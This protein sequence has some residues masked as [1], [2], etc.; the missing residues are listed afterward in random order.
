M[1]S[2]KYILTAL[3][4]A[5]R[6]PANMYTR[7]EL[8]PDQ[9]PANIYSRHCGHSESGKHTHGI[10][11][12]HS[13]SGEVGIGVDPEGTRDECH[14]SDC[15]VNVIQVV[16]PRSD[17]WDV[18][19]LSVER[20]HSGNLRSILCTTTLRRTYPITKKNPVLLIHKTAGSTK[21]LIWREK[22][23]IIIIIIITIKK[24]IKKSY[25]A[26]FFNKNYYY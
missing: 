3:I 14:E 15:G 16:R 17:P 24:N 5:I 21:Q 8:R 19:F 6:S 9:I 23:I 11:C 26:L 18:Y 25:K 2:G 7:H 1:K 12:G 22:R 10:N 13:Q 4:V 20:I